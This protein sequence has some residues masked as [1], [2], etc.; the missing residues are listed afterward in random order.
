MVPI[1]AMQEAGLPKARKRSAP[2]KMAASFEVGEAT[3]S[4]YAQP[5]GGR[6][7]MPSIPNL[8]MRG[9]HPCFYFLSQGRPS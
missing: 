1:A 7:K 2:I 4:R 3:P 6:G 8:N 9:G 5:W